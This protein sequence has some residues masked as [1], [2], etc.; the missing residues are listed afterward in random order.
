MTSKGLT[1]E[2]TIYYIIVVAKWKVCPTL[3]Y[4][5]HGR[6]WPDKRTCR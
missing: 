5:D 4:Q 6:R 3:R 2:E 1:Q